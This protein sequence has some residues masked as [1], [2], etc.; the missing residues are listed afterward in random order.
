MGHEGL[1]VVCAWCET[2]VRAGGV[3]VSHGI[4][5]TC[6]VGFLNTLPADYLRSIADPDGT[7]TLFSG[8]KFAVG[9][10]A[11]VARPDGSV[12]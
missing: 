8:V 12:G 6:A 2:T 1:T 11:E 3:Q 5:T 10:A 4:C 7:V 9:A